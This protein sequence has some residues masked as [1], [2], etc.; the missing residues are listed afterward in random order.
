LKNN[1][2]TTVKYQPLTEKAKTPAAFQFYSRA[3]NIPLHQNITREEQKYII[4]NIYR[5]FDD[6]K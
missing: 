6:E 2:Y 5:F 3:L 4:K 1:I